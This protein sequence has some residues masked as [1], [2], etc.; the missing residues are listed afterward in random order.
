MNILK[1]ILS[2][3]AAAA[4]IVGLSNTAY[5]KNTYNVN[6][7][8]GADRYKTSLS[9]ANNFNNGTVQNI[10]IASG[11]D[12]PDALAGS[13]LSKKFNAPILLLKDNLNE[14][15]ETIEYIKS[16][17][18]KNGTIYVLGGTASVKDD[19]I[20]YMKQSGYNN[21]TRLGGQNRFDTNKSIVKVMNVE[22]GTPVVI[23]NGYGFADAL[24]VSSVAASKGYPIFMTGDSKLPEETKNMLS[25]IQP[26][27]VYII[28]GQGSVKDVVLGELKTLVP[29]LDN[30]KIVRIDGQTRY[31]TSLNISKYFNLDTDTAVLA[32]GTNFPDALSGSALASK[33]NAPIILT[34][35]TDVSA[36]KT[37]IYDKN[38]KNMILLGG[39]GS[40]DLSVE[41][42]FK[43]AVGIPQSQKDYVNKLKDYCDSY[44][45]ENKNATISLTKTF[46]KIN[47]MKDDMNVNNIY[48]LSNGIGKIITTFQEGSSQLS[49]YKNNLIKLRNEASTL[50]APEGLESLKTEYVNSINTQIQAVDQSIG[51]I[52]KYI[53]A[54]DS[55]KD[56][57]DYGDIQKIEIKARE[58]EDLTKS[59]D[60][61]KNIQ[62][63]DQAMSRLYNRISAAVNNMQ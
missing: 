20:S 54:F 23:A 10:I 60:S 59:V 22:K 29:S 11:K 46:D 55:L 36:Q 24:S 53:A 35:G 21:I 6:R 50:S 9:I 34:N 28:G 1:K 40:I 42:L 19:F 27:Q 17:L 32:N 12:F 41:Y 30:S 49:N 38:Y 8:S 52:N 25:T 57:L 31:E 15:G 5:A 13:V 51:Y 56:G 2:L 48:E 44:V 7:L 58:I 62:S 63:G 16:H 14:S 43:D 47:S 18:D 26:S 4:I 3:V 37:F 33:F 39:I 45:N 61:M